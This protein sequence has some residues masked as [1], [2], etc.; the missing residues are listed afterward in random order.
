MIEK[1]VGRLLVTVLFFNILMMGVWLTNAAIL[2]LNSGIP[3][4]FSAL[5]VIILGGVAYLISLVCVALI[6][7]DEWKQ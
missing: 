4:F 5:F 6:C 3:S 7:Y 2:V 1:W